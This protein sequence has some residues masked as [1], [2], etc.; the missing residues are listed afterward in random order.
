MDVPALQEAPEGVIPSEDLRFYARGMFASPLITHLGE[1]AG[2][3]QHRRELGQGPA[4]DGG[5]GWR[6]PCRA[7][8]A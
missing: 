3:A 1:R 6:T 7:G 5:C 2:A 8:S 4:V